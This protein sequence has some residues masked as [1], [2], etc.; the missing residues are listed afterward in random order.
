M[1]PLHAALTLEGSPEIPP[2][3]EASSP[4]PPSLFPRLEHFGIECVVPRT[5]NAGQDPVVLDVFEVQRTG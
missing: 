1:L 5:L 4:H 3:A 2:P